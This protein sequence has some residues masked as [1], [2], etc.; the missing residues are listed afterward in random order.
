[1]PLRRVYFEDT[2]EFKESI[3]FVEG[4]CGVD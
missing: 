1:M 4:D 2:E 3:G